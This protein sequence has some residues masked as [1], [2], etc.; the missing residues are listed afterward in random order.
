[1][2]CDVSEVQASSTRFL[3]EQRG[4]AIP[5]YFQDHRS[6]KTGIRKLREEWLPRDDAISRRQMVISFS[7]GVICVKHPQMA[8]QFVCYVADVAREVRVARVEANAHVYRK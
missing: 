6:L 2:F 1:M 5:C 8:T 7:P 4:V 3:E